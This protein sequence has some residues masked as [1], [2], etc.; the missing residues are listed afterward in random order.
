MLPQNGAE[1]VPLRSPLAGVE[2]RPSKRVLP[3]YFWIGVNR[4]AGEG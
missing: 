4:Q 2:I 1:A 3:N